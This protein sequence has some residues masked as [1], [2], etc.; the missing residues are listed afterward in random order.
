MRVC[1]FSVGLKVLS[2]H[3]KFS[4]INCVYLLDLGLMLELFQEKHGTLSSLLD[5][6]SLL[7][8]NFSSV[9][10]RLSEQAGDSNRMPLISQVN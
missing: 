5:E 10:E 7:V 9:R 8:T 4:H 6:L 2:I 3:N 1:D